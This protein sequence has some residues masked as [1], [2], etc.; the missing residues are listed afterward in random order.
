[1]SREDDFESLFRAEY[2]QV[3]RSVVRIVVSRDIAEEVAQEAFC[4]AYER[5]NRV[6]RHERP[7]AW[8]QT[9]A[10]RLALRQQRRALRGAQLA[11][12][13][14]AGRPSEASPD[15]EMDLHRAIEGLSRRQREA[16][17]LHHLVGLPV[18]EVALVMR[19]E[20]GTIKT[21]LHRGRQRLGIAL[22]DD[23][24]MFDG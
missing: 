3:V 4:R 17:T 8:V 20:I 11:S 7:G 16:V 21:Q 22:A 23:G 6:C 13:L 24:G 5:W 15:S 9:T 14:H 12:L 19:V 1:M 10:L 2:G 18:A